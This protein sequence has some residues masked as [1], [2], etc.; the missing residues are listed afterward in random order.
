MCNCIEK[1][2][3]ALEKKILKT[4]GKE[5]GFVG[6]TSSGFENE[7]LLMTGNGSK[8][9]IVIPFIVEYQRK[10]KVSGNIKTYKKKVNYFPS[11]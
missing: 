4:V 3:K 11:F 8:V 2:S 5:T 10:S 7:V 9:P 6:I 1:T